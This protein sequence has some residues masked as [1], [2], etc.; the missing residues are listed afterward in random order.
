ML[1]RL[2]QQDE[3]DVVVIGAGATGLGVALDAASRGMS[4]LIVD[5]QDWASGHASRSGK[6]IGGDVR[7]IACPHLWGRVKE[8]L[9]E[10]RL[11]LQN[12][13]SLVRAQNFVIPLHKNKEV[14]HKAPT[15]TEPKKF[16][17]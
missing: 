7:A 6:H 9:Y 14:R 17:S 2:A 5:A 1:E 13:P 15:K 10:R 4:V 3:F 16:F 8:A 12:A 11:L